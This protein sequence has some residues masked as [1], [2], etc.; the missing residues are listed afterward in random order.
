MADTRVQLEVEDWVR[1]NWM[2]ETYGQKFARERVKLRSGGYFDFD[3]VS[4]DDTIVA[5]ISTSA[6]I[7]SGGKN[8]V[9]KMMKIRS[10]M[11]FLSMIEA[12][13]RII[14]LTEKDMFDKC[15][16]ETNGGRVPPEIEFALAVIPDDLR[17]KLKKARDLSSKEVSPKYTDA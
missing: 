15:I 12:K 11:L 8:G 16:L 10:D 17:E 14:V 5:S 3:A 9:G 2:R 7:T 1:A 13:R 6:S 4:G